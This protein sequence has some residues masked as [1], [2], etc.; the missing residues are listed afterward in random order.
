MVVITTSATLPVFGEYIHD[1]VE[2]VARVDSV[3]AAVLG[4]TTFIVAT[5]GINIVANFV[6]PAFD[7]S[8]VSPKHITFIRG[9]M[10]AA[11]G[12]VF[13]MPWHLFNSPD[14]IHYTLDTLGAAIG[15]LY[16]ILVVD[17]FMVK[18]EKLYRRR[19]L[20][21]QAGRPLLVQQGLQPGRG[22]GADRRLL[23]GLL[24][25]VIP[26]LYF[27]ASFSWGIGAAVGATTY[28]KLM[29][30]QGGLAVARD[31]RGRRKM[32][33]NGNGATPLPT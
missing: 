23:R 15:P 10:I 4:A 30:G 33:L 32:A 17:Y 20:Q 13:V 7:F 8:N 31:E 14:V 16:G 9:G 11:V 1:P 21:R 29:K 24:F 26:Q 6:S 18:H 2:I 5:I 19:S 3:V 22:Q 12:S 25:V 28:V 27:L